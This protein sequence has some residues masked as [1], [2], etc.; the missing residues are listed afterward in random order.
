MAVATSEN[1]K[2]LAY[3]CDKCIA[4][5]CSVYER[6]QVT[7][8]DVLRIA[9]HFRLTPEAAKQRFT[10]KF[11]GETILRRKFDPLFGRSCTFLDKQTRKC[12]IYDARPQTCRIFPEAPR[13]AYFDLL[14]F[15]REQQQDPDVIPIV[16]VTFK[17]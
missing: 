8:R 9:R 2:P 15:E 6:V 11:E 12:T 1:K 13:C 7:Q 3:D 14:E 10:K 17:D 5:C 16:K 4:Y